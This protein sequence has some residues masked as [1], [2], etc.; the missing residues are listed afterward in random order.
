MRE[1][2]SKA[3]SAQAEKLEWRNFSNDAQKIQRLKMLHAKHT[4]SH[5]AYNHTYKSFRKKAV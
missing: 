2:F 5:V 4:I 1:S 3:Q